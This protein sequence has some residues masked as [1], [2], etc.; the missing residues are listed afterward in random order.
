MTKKLDGLASLHKT[1]LTKERVYGPHYWETAMYRFDFAIQLK[2][3]GAETEATREMQH[4]AAACGKSLGPDHHLAVRA[5][6]LSEMWSKE[7]EC[8]SRAKAQLDGLEDFF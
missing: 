5:R 4:A 1:L 6:S 8:T 7:V 3:I 2:N